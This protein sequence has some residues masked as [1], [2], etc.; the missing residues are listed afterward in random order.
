MRKCAQCHRLKPSARWV[1]VESACLCDSCLRT[2]FYECAG[3]AD[4]L[5]NEAEEIEKVLKRRGIK[6]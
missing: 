6:P 2:R 4:A 3:E 5:E 1:Y